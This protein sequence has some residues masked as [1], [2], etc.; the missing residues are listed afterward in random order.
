M[1]LVTP[2]S[3]FT[4]LFHLLILSS[5]NGYKEKELYTPLIIKE[6]LQFCNDNPGFS[7]NGVLRSKANE[8]FKNFIIPKIENG[9]LNDYIFELNG[10][11]EFEPGKYAAHFEMSYLGNEYLMDTDSAYVH[12]DV[13]GIIDSTLIDNLK[14]K[15]KYKLTGNYLGHLNI[16]ELKSYS[17]FPVWSPLITIQKE[18]YSSPEASLGVLKFNINGVE[19]IKQ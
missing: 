6:I 5:C 18:E 14:E 15:G 7:N 17:I 1:K 8:E 13:I 2:I 4:F 16:E 9:L 11:K 19:H 12:G 3:I 10:V